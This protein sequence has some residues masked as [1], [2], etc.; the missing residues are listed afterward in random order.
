VNAP[1][2]PAPETSIVIPTHGGRFLRAAVQSVMAQ[3]VRGWELIIV[4][5]GSRDGTAE[6]AAALAA[7]DARIRV[8]TQG[9][10]GIA[11]ARNRGLAETAKASAYVAFLD[12]DDLWMPDALEVLRAALQARPSASAAHGRALTL[13]ERGVPVEGERG[14]GLPGNR[15]AVVD[16]RVQLWPR[17]RP[18]EFAVLA[19]D[20]CIVG[21]GSALMR[22]SALLRVGGFD[23]RAEPADDYDLWVR[24]SRVGEIAFTE[25]VVLAYRLHGENRSL[26]PP[27]A[28]GRGAGYVRHKLVTSAENSPAQRRIAVAGFRAHE[29]ALLAERWRRIA[30]AWARGERA[31]A[32]RLL[33]GG[34]LRL[35]G[36]VRGCP[37][38]WQR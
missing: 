22:R 9:R 12:H 24:M 32:G 23:G 38:R 1:S 29:R 16:G 37:W 31:G 7:A 18:T 3:T 6:V 4:D 5:D 20:D 19:Y 10:A 13:D 17:E 35:A 25:A 30:A 2:A 33:A 26:R 27:P 34:L 14:A 21:V 8:V 36:Y 28:R 11:A 15:R